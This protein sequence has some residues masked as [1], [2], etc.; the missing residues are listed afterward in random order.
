MGLLDDAAKAVEGQRA[1]RLRAVPND[2]PPP[3]EWASCEQ[4]PDGRAPASTPRPATSQGRTPILVRLSDI[5]PAPIRWLWPGWLALGKVG[6]LD[7]DPGLGKST[8]TLDIAARVTRGGLMPG[9]S[10]G[11][12]RGT[13]AGVVLLSCEDDPADTLRPRLDAAGAD[14]TRVVAMPGVV[15]AKGERMPSLSDIEAIETAIESVGAKLVIIDPL[16]AYLSGDAHRDNEVRQS[17]GPVATMAARLGVA[18][19]VVRHLNKGGGSNPLYRGGGSIA[20]TGAVRT[21]MIM[22]RD[23]DDDA[24]RVVAATKSNIAEMPESLGFRLVQSGLASRVEW[25][26]ASRHAARD[27]LSA[28]AVNHEPTARD[29][30]A[31]WLRGELAAGPKPVRELQT[32]ARRAGHTWRTIERAKSTL[33]VRARR[34]G[35]GGESR[36]AGAWTW[37]TPS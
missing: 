22:A 28:E 13:P 33:G 12:L 36:G 20:I 17:L 4:E 5:E 32:E 8:L 9:G 25:T 7:G 24:A 30:A 34:Q 11:A 6:L 27:L 37:E 18:V 35:A 31:D 1:K 19:L 29:E 3:I 2:E 10:P 15:D 14:C 16:M 23:P 26:G 21:G